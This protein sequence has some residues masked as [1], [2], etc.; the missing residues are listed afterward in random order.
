M[1]CQPARFRF[2]RKRVT[3]AIYQQNGHGQAVQKLPY[4]EIM[5]DGQHGEFVDGGP[6]RYFCKLLLDQVAGESWWGRG[7]VLSHDVVDDDAAQE[8]GG[9]K[10][11]DGQA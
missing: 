9:E 1:L 3:G 11:F 5:D 7:C 10:E 8:P 4:I 6:S 2:W